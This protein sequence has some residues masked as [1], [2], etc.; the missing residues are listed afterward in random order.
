VSVGWLGAGSFANGVLLPA[1]KKVPDIDF[2][3]VCNANGSHSRQAAEKFG[4]RYCTTDEQKIISDPGVTTLA[5]STRHHLHATQV[6]A[7][8]GAG[9]HVFC[10][11]P[12]C[13]NE[14]ELAEILQAHAAQAGQS[15]L[16]VGFNRRFA[17]MAQKT[18]SFLKKIQEPLSLHYRVNAGFIP[19]DHWV[20]DPEQG[21]G[22]ILGEVCHFIDFLIFLAESQPV[23]VHT[24]GLSDTGQY[25]GDNVV[26]AIQFFNGSQGTITYLA[27][28][29]R[30]FSKER[31]EVFGGGAVAVLEDFRCLELVRHGRKQTMRSRLRQ[32]KGHRAEWD[33]FAAAIKAGSESTIL[34]DD[35]VA[36][37][38]TTFGALESR[39][40]GQPVAIEVAR[41]IQSN[42]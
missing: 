34:I 24:R 8:L 38:L 20:N 25:S 31:I 3:G 40:T 35:I 19:D 10:E 32:D 15:L 11:K 22:R 1:A 21:G 6:V 26:I 14:G 41:F 36:T 28:G 4:F 39:S 2:V 18:K 27:N 5:I 17:P 30:S 16:T 13:L 7:G 33:A 12:L 37:T 9:K 29:D 42:S 23:E